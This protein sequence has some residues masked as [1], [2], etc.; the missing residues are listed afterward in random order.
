M[1]GTSIEVFS[2]DSSAGGLRHDWSDS[3]GWHFENLDGT[4]SIGPNQF[5]VGLYSSTTMSGSSLEALYY[6]SQWHEL[7]HAW[8]DANGWHFENLDGLGGSP[9]SRVGPNVDVGSYPLAI[10]Y[11]SVFQ[12]FY[13]DAMHGMLRHAWPQ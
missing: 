8:T 13:Y 12:A 2:Y 4:G 11:G 10:V 3:T 1:D 9:S 5:T 6:D 7:R